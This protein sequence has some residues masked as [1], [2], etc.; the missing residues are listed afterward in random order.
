MKL[1]NLL[2]A[3]LMLC[4]AI[5]SSGC[6]IVSEDGHYETQCY[7]DCEDIEV[8]ERVCDDWECWDSCWIETTC[9]EVCEDVYVVVEEVEVGEQDSDEVEEEDDVEEQESEKD[10]DAI[11][12]YSTP[13]CSEGEFCDENKCYV[14]R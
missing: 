10:L 5:F 2:G 13:D 8:C 7:D 12:C 3:L 11:E 6:L 14:R 4:V 9:D 1:T